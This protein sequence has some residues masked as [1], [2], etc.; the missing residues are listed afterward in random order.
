[1]CLQLYS[2]TVTVSSSSYVS[3]SQKRSHTA[4]Q[5]R[6]VLP[7]NSGSTQKP[8]T[9]PVKS[10]PKNSSK[11]IQGKSVS[12]DS[13]VRSSSS[14]YHSASN[15]EEPE[16]HVLSYAAIVEHP[17]PQSLV[18]S[19]ESSE[20]R[21]SHDKKP[22]D[23]VSSHLSFGSPSSFSLDQLPRRQQSGVPRSPAS[24]SSTSSSKHA[25]KPLATAASHYSTTSSDNGKASRVSS[26]LLIQEFR[27]A[28]RVWNSESVESVLV[29][30]G[31]DVDMVIN[32]KVRI[33]VV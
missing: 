11:E 14:S 6:E 16:D 24:N 8:V 17:V 30:G 28:V 4:Q 3:Q 2:T 20:R 27:E 22:G 12:P 25:A 13:L 29:K 10:K 9:M 31:V 19:K 33:L 5:M 23:Q 18:H 15:Y 21:T 7:S 1:M 26:E 32:E